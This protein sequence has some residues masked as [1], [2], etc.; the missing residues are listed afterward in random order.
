V[1]PASAAGPAASQATGQ[2][3][4]RATAVD[5]GRTRGAASDTGM[6]SVPPPPRGGRRID[7]ATVL[8]LG[9][10][11]GLVIA[12]L[13]L[14]GS[15]GAFWDLPSVLITIGGTIAVTTI[16]FAWSEVT[17]GVRMIGGTLMSSLPDPQAVARFVVHV[18]DAARSSGVV[19]L[20]PLIAAARHDPLLQRA[21][22]MIVDGLP[23]EEVER[24]LRTE[25]EADQ[26]R[27]RAGAA[28]LRR[29]AEVAPAMGLIGTLVGLVQMLGNLSTPSAIGPAMAVAL[30]TTF[31]GAVLGSMVLT[32]LAGKV[33]RN[34]DAQALNASLYMLA[35]ASMARQENPRRLEMIVNTVLPP[36]LRLSSFA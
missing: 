5:G 29:A 4:G 21:M 19:S 28:V 34:A 14:G 17:A 13:L 6:V 36:E 2:T 1:Q 27:A 32:P 15:L 10:S 20:Q 25:I 3:A 22:A 9:G 33:E 26:A 35:A 23:A 31:Y 11:F 12:A 18:A 7:L 30:L 8:G 24:I 16:S